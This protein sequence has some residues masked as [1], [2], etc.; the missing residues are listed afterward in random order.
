VQEFSVDFIISSGSLSVSEI[1]AIVGVDCDE[2]SQEMGSANPIGE[3]RESSVWRINSGINKAGTFDDHFFSLF[4]K[5][6]FEKMNLD[7][8]PEGTSVYV[9]VGIFTDF[10]AAWY[11]SSDAISR[12]HQYG[13]ELEVSCYPCSFSEEEEEE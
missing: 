11:L 6:D 3:I 5:V 2:D 10:T 12:L 7:Q 9:D 8:L 13:I 4:R 1:S